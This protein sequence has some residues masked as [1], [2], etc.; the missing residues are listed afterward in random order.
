[1]PI[2]QN[3]KY[4]MDVRHTTTAALSEKAN[5]PAPTITK[6]RTG[7]TKNPNAD[8]LQRIAK[9][10]DVSINDLTDTPA[11]DDD[12][13]RD[14][15]PKKLPADNEELVGMIVNTL[16]NQRISN[17]RTMAELRKD[18][19]F[20]RQ[21][22]IICVGIILPLLIVTFAIT[23]FMYWDLSHPTEGNI[24]IGSAAEF[25]EYLKQ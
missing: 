12:E 20:W 13:L 3:L 4:W 11:I 10:L 16:R 6:I 22:L 7:E 5:I 23:C 24:I 17:E 19:N 18:R 15:L 8:T 1:M 9:A 21:M 25:A 14:L 2:S